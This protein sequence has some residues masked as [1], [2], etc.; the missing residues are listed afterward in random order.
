MSR[1]INTDALITT[2]HNLA[3]RAD[4]LLAKQ[5]EAAYPG[6]AEELF[7]L[8][9]QIEELSNELAHAETALRILFD[10]TRRLNY[11]AIAFAEVFGTAM[12]TEDD[13]CFTTSVGLH[14][15]GERF[16]GADQ[17]DEGVPF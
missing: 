10:I 5:G 7:Q 3:D 6:V 13:F 16:G 17:I 2:I 15:F 4:E 1:E 12:P 11:R 8:G 9:C 14:A